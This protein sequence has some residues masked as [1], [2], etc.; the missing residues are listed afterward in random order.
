MF[1]VQIRR[2]ADRVD[3]QR[4][5]GEA[6]WNINGRSEYVTGLE[7]E[8]NPMALEHAQTKIISVINVSIYDH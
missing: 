7:K 6:S 1:S 2:W 4:H 5:G 3:G 8:S